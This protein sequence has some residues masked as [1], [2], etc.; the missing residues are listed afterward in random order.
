MT[1]QKR[2]LWGIGFK[3]PKLCF[4][5]TSQ[6]SDISY[7]AHQKTLTVQKRELIKRNENERTISIHNSVFNDGISKPAIYSKINIR[8]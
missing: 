7:L 1:K 5:Q 3:Y 8:S 2:L 6:G 4:G